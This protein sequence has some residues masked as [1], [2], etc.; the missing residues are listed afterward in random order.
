MCSK[1]TFFYEKESRW[2]NLGKPVENAVK[3][4]SS[5]INGQIIIRHTDANPGEKYFGKKW[6]TEDLQRKKVI[7]TE[8]VVI[9]TNC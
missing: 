4:K 5:E 8:K 1:V 9:V 3:G 7:L 6:T 2:E